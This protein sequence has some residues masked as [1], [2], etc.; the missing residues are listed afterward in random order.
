MH[1]G[2]AALLFAVALAALES[3]AAPPVA[4]VADVRGNA[5]IEGNGPLTF[6]AELPPGTRVLLGTNAMAAITYALSGAEYSIAGPGQFLVGL[7]EVVA[8]RGASPR[9][10]SVTALGDSTVVAK[11]AH[12]AT[13]SLR[14]RGL[15]PKPPPAMLEYPVSTRVSSLRPQMRWRATPGEEYTVVVQDAAGRDF[16]RG[17]GKAA[18]IKPDVA[19]AAGARYSWSVK[20]A[21]GAIAEAHFE[22]LPQEAIRRAER[23]RHG[24]QREAD[25]RSCRFYVDVVNDPD[26]CGVDWCPLAAHSLGGG[27]AFDNNQYFLVQ[28]CAHG[29]DGQ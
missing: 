10:R 15:P 22:T 29:I 2:P 13:A 21:G 9:H 18:G 11:A 8:E 24:R 6:L 28:S 23:S 19:L 3:R 7:A 14:M 5:T 27:A 1:A 17:R 26:N 25:L 4:F 20:G 16:W 12:T